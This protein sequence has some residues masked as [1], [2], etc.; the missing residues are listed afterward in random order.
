MARVLVESLV[1]GP[2]KKN[3]KNQSTIEIIKDFI[4]HS[5]HFPNMLSYGGKNC[6]MQIVYSYCRDAPDN[7][8]LS[9][10]CNYSK[11]NIC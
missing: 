1:N 11:P 8:V 4:N 6:V 5:F 3:F 10:S 7:S 2:L 9:P